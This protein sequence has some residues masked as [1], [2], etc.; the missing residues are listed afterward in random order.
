MNLLTHCALCGALLETWETRP[1]PMPCPCAPEYS[2]QMRYF[3][4][5]LIPPGVIPPT[6][7]PREKAG[8]L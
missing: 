2:R 5:G 4:R 7:E 1:L 6:S 3:R 8:E